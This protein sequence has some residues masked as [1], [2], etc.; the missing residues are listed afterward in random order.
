MYLTTEASR[1]R[2]GQIC[3]TNTVRQVDG[4][5]SQHVVLRFTRSFEAVF[6]LFLL[7]LSPYDVVFLSLLPEHGPRNLGT[8]TGCGPLI[9]RRTK[10]FMWFVQELNEVDSPKE[11]LDS[12]LSGSMTFLFVGT[13]VKWIIVLDHAVPK[14]NLVTVFL[15]P[16][17]LLSFLS[18]RFKR[19]L[20][21]A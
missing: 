17:P 20:M 16:M 1:H 8:V 19:E 11:P 5:Q 13:L 15:P 3:V 21:W 7:L 18:L 14:V 2:F 9:M 10:Q 12:W 4:M 6:I